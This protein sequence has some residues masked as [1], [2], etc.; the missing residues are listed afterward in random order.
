MRVFSVTSA[1]TS[2]AQYEFPFYI[3][4]NIASNTASE[5]LDT[6][7]VSLSPLGHAG[8]SPRPS[9]LR[10]ARD[11][12]TA[13]GNAVRR[14]AYA[15]S[16]LSRPASCADSVSSVSPGLEDMGLSSNVNS[17]QDKHRAFSAVPFLASDMRN[18]TANSEKQCQSTSVDGIA[19][20]RTPPSKVN[21]T[22]EGYIETDT[23][24]KRC[25][26]Q[27][28]DPEQSADKVKMEVSVQVDVNRIDS[29]KEEVSLWEL[30]KTA[31]N[32]SYDLSIA[33]EKIH[34]PRGRPRADGRLPQ[35]TCRRL[36]HTLSASLSEIETQRM[37]RQKRKR[38]KVA[39]L[40]CHIF[41][42]RLTV[43]GIIFKVT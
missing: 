15:G 40:N 11:S 37:K 1:S 14:L 25:R 9:I 18:C 23:P 24:R 17:S 4:L 36:S 6:A 29:H 2:N 27:Q 28:F 10:K 13:S 12:V 22:D 16:P 33:R 31:Q 30:N 20:R 34:R 38:S 35:K 3:P 5:I 7:P 32:S 19:S 42:C 26:K 8:P 39:L 41:L 21:L 43:F